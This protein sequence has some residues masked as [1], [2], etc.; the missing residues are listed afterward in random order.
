MY[1]GLHPGL[2]LK[3]RSGN[4]LCSLEGFF[5][6]LSPFFHLAI[7]HSYLMATGWDRI[8]SPSAPRVKSRMPTRARFLRL[9]VR[10]ART[11]LPCGAFWVRE[12]SPH[13]VSVRVTFS[14]LPKS[15]LPKCV[16]HFWLPEQTSSASLSYLG[17]F[18]VSTRKVTLLFN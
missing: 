5:L 8:G 9:S 15:G 2:E 16:E 13:D 7:A 17:H 10:V 4:S 11:A 18:F 14:C 12:P 3:L 6:E 1:W